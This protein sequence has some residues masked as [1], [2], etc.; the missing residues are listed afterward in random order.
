MKIE[1][2]CGT[3]GSASTIVPTFDQRSCAGMIERDQMVQ[4]YAIWINAH[5]ECKGTVKS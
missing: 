5:K 2:R 3:C 4:M 1:A